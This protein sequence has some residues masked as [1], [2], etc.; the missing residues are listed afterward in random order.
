LT[1]ERL[2][3]YLPMDRR[4]ALAAGESLLVD[5]TGAAL[6]ADISGFTPLTEAL[7]EGLGPRRGA[8]ELTKLLN[9]IYSGLISR[10][11]HF[12]G[13]VVCFI[14]DALVS[15][16]PGD[17]AVRALACG[18][19][20]QRTMKQFQ[21]IA[22]PQGGRVSLAMKAAVS[23]GAARRFLIG[24]PT[25]QLL[26]VL[27]GATVDRLTEAEHVAGRGEVVASPEV[28]Q[29]LGAQLMLGA[30]RGRI[31]VVEGLR[32]NVEPAPWPALPPDG[33]T[34][35]QIRPYLLR[36][37]YEAVA[38][39]QGEFLAELRPVSVLFLRFAG[40]D[41]DE[42][43]TAGQKLD[44]F[45]RWVQGTANR[46]G[47]HVLL[48]TTADKGSHLYVV[49]GAL[50]A[51]EDD[52]RRAVAAAAKLS[53]PP[54]ELG[55]VTSVQ[56]GVSYGRARVGAYGGEF[57][58]TYGALG[59][60]V[61]LAARLME[62]APVGEIRCCNSIYEVAKNQWAFDTLPAV[63]LKGMDRPQLVYR[64][65][66]RA[67]T[68]T[69]DEERALVGRQAELEAIGAALEEARAG[70]RRILLMDGEAGIGKS[71]LVEE[72]RR[73][74][75]EGGFSC[76]VGAADSIERHTP[77][78]AW[79]D[80]LLVL[81]DLD[82]LED[83]AKRRE[84]VLERVEAIDSAL[85]DRAP[86][87]N[88]VLELDL[89]ESRLTRGYDSEVRQESLAALIGELLLD[90]T[91]TCPLVLI[92]EDAHWMDSLSWELVVSVAR[93][94]ANR[95][96]LLVLTHRPYPD[97]VPPPFIA[98]SE[99]SGAGRLPVGSLP[100]EETVALA[101]ERVGLV[102]SAIPEVV[103]SLLAE[104]SGGNPFFAVE[105]IGSLR[106]QELL[107]IE[108]DGCTVTS[109]ANALRESVPDTLEGVV[110]S[111][112]DLLPTEEQLTLKVASVIGPSFLLRTL[113]CAYP[114]RIAE[115]A[116]RTHLDH[117]SRR[118]LTLLEAEDPEPAFAF[119][120]VVTQ[121]GAYGTLLF[122][123]RRELHRS[124]ADWYERTYAEH[125]DP[126]YPLLVVH[127]NRA[128][129]EEKE[130]EYCRR[131]GEQAA[132][133]HANAEAEIY[134]TRALELIEGLDRHG[135]SERRIELLQQ[136]AGI[137]ALLG[138]VEEERGD[139]ERLLP[140]VEKSKDASKR[141]DMLLL[142]ASFHQRCG[143][144]D[145]SK[146]QAELA[147]AAMEEKGDSTGRARALT[148]I[149]NALEGEGRFQE[150]R[151]FVQ[152]ALDTFTDGDALDGQAASLKSL[153]IINARLGE[154]SQAMECFRQA[155]VLYRALG[156]RKGEADIL[157]NLGALK[158]YL[159]DYEA[160]IEST[161]Q[162]QPLFHEMGNRIGSA[163]CLTNLG[164]SYSALGA[165]AEALEH[166]ERALEVYEQLEDASGSA[167]SLCNMGI[168][169]GTLGVG[170]Q[171]ELTFRTQEEGAHLGAAIENTQ[172][173]LALYTQIGSQRGELIGRFNLGVI[174]LSLG[175]AKAAET[176]LVD[177]L[178]MGR[179]L[180]LDRLV[181]RALSA[182]ARSRLLAGE[183]E[184]AAKLS[185]EAI[186]LLGDQT[187]AEAIEIHFTQFRV[188]LISDEHD[189]AIHHLEVAHSLVAKQAETI[190][191]ASSRDRFLSAY[192]ELLSAWEKHRATSPG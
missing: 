24:D 110:L 175:D 158:Y 95:P 36:P 64:P 35:E 96:A 62:A 163:K 161:E 164:N 127:W 73:L 130:C 80:L 63:K 160:C 19:Q 135:K 94:L 72:L 29:K 10:I 183:R 187:T 147:L 61:N 84:R 9:A 46:F 68:G 171:L 114:A 87:L 157:G 128:G 167:D 58:R 76:L 137:L 107:V 16:F 30:W 117:T 97:V 99:M 90:R 177:A 1:I 162:A 108:G 27:V 2:G 40:I 3:T 85:V 74:A 98:L 89:P 125:L 17:Q 31:G 70:S 153:G 145:R 79:R 49:F 132:A 141:G 121:Q 38:A 173:A 190:K 69:P 182:L 154:L 113:H 13:T 138:R 124:V 81:F 109:D 14:G 86:L 192:G 42:D 148:Q 50:E 170:G 32:A 66:G 34:S 44:V 21:A 122:E 150:A 71:R 129:H 51:H 101:A 65:R 143:Q 120:H 100:P 176:E 22:A 115:A 75:G 172:K 156:D 159:G 15:W 169:H 23:V 139:L 45:T 6:L 166:H 111:R 152:R 181:M 189:Q 48:L 116:L 168:A 136:R 186:D 12:G 174:Y 188:L 5:A 56:I 25:I 52:H 33:L 146:E 106:D 118:R 142:W 54:S 82:G 180:G 151:E 126:H 123:Q 37:V 77:Y 88:D 191:G 7:V 133:R 92:I 57:R 60:A 43:D 112:L 83:L 149:G 102:P 184:E 18:L 26:D 4:Q 144:F 53:R 155:R 28:A 41:Y 93:T 39:G 185:S 131:A 59:D 179:G 47:G 103:A 119:Q 55:F 165:F 8:E 91:A 140:I 178:R 67:W 134:F 78:R 104:R 11:H 20:M 105:L